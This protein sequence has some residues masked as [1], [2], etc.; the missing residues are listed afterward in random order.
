MSIRAFETIVA[1][2]TGTSKAPVALVRLSGPEA[3]ALASQVIKNAPE[4]P[5]S[6]RAYYVRFKNGDDGLAVFFEEGRSFTGEQTVEFSLH[7]SPYSISSHIEAL[8]QLGARLAEPGE[9]TRRAFMNGKLD[10]TAAEAVQEVIDST[11]ETQFRAATQMVQGSLQRKVRELREHAV[12]LVAELEARVDFEEEVGPL[13]REQ[14]ALDLRGLVI[15]ASSLAETAK[16]GRLLRKGFRVALLGRPNAGKSS[17]LNRLLQQDRAIVSSTPGTTR[18][19]ITE[20]VDIGGVACILVDTAGL[21]P[22]EDETEAVGVARSHEQASL[23]DVSWYLYDSSVGWT[24]ADMDLCE[25]IK[26]S[27]I[28]ANKVDLGAIIASDHVPIS[29]LTGEGVE[30]LVRWVQERVPPVNYYCNDR[31]AGIIEN[32]LPSLSTC[33]GAFLSFM[34][35]DFLVTCLRDTISAF[36]AMLGTDLSADVLDDL[37]SHF[38]VGK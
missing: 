35:D 36:D 21:R 23:A 14:F 31:H 17:L 18:D 29:S 27:L 30:H 24:Q 38:C 11:T 33:E 20:A 10:L 15:E 9:F 19:F 6:H 5:E 25:L 12:R 7:G 28:L 26:P 8:I 37:F 34:P 16:V 22:T 32:A 3:W 2:I 13:D 4:G 1:P